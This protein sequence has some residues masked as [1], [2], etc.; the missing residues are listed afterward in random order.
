MQG[1]LSR[2]VDLILLVMSEAGVPIT[3]LH[4]IVGM[5]CLIGVGFLVCFWVSRRVVGVDAELEW[6]EWKDVALE[7]FRGDVGLQQV[8]AMEKDVLAS[9]Q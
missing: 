4:S 7:R 9:R 5:I 8:L 2:R 6:A 1:Y 3:D